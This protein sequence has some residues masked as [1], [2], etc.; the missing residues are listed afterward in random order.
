MSD[1]IAALKAR[2][3]ADLAERLKELAAL[4]GQPVTALGVA[5]GERVTV[6]IHGAI[7]GVAPAGVA[8]A[9]DLATADPAAPPPAVLATFNRLA[10]AAVL[11]E[12]LQRILGATRTAT[13]LIEIIAAAV[14]IVVWDD[15]WA[16]GTPHVTDLT[17]PR[18][19]AGALAEL[20][21][22]A[23]RVLAEDDPE[24]RG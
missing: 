12:D 23:R 15:T 16:A 14:A 20:G 2:L 8:A 3:Q 24:A 22:E 5:H 9:F 1:D 7:E 19:I 18:L 11:A 21:D 10:S 4:T 13:S 17:I 6:A